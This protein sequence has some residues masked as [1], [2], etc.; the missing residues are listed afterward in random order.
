MI[1]LLRFPALVLT[2]L[3]TVGTVSVKAD[4]PAAGGHGYQQ[5]DLQQLVVLCATE[6]GSEKFARSWVQWLEMNPS[7]DVANSVRTIVGR[8]RTM[9]SMMLAGMAHEHDASQPSD[10]EIAAWMSALADQHLSRPATA[11]VR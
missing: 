10:A 8:A 4:Q 6:P 2:A 5:P 3:L 11:A 9:R 7:A 1:C